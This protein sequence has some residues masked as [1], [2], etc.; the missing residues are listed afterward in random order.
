M[1]IVVHSFNK[2]PKNVSTTNTYRVR[3]HGWIGHQGFVYIK[4]M[5]FLRMARP[6]IVSC[7]LHFEVVF[8]HTP[9]LVN[10]W[11]KDNLFFFLHGQHNTALQYNYAGI[12]RRMLYIL[13]GF[14]VNKP[15]SVLILFHGYAHGNSGSASISRQTCIQGPYSLSHLIW[16]KF[17]LVFTKK[18]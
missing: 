15:N 2:T 12:H 18:L 11:R 1:L 8:K 5:W 9:F 13:N 17:T 4:E 7:L 14:D 10:T 6:A 3:R 16:T